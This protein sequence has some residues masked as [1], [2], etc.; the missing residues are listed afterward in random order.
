MPKPRPFPSHAA[1]SEARRQALMEAMADH[2]LANGLAGSPL[3]AL[4]AAAGTSDRMLL[5][6][7]ADRAALL[8]ALLTHVAGRLAAL[9]E[10]S[11]DGRERSEAQMLTDLWAAART[12]ALG[13][14]MSLFLDL[15]TAAGRGEQPHKAI[16]AQ[17]AH[18]FSVWIGQRLDAPPEERSA[19]AF[20]LMA[21]LDGLY[22]LR[23]LGLAAEADA[24]AALGPDQSFAR[25]T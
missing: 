4:A 11:D 14:Y 16:A 19:R 21:Q 5:Y 18:G 20:R 12:P 10:A 6:Y 22:L 8:S 2:L 15:A 7:F 25:S 1:P 3:R 9:L 17:I 13:P 23:G 24:A